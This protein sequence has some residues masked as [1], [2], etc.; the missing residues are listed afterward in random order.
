MTTT[1]PRGTLRERNRQRIR[2]DIYESAMALFTKKGYED[3][4]IDD[5]VEE[6]GV[7]KATF[8]RSFESK[9]GLVDEFNQRMADNI[10]DSIDLA[11]MSPTECIRV[12]TD[13]IFQEWLQSAPQMRN[14][15]LEFVRTGTRISEQLTDPMTRGMVPILVSIIESGQ[16]QGEF[17]PDL[18]PR[19]VAALIVYAW[20]I[21]SVNWFD[22]ADE[23]G[24]NRS[25]HGLVELQLRG[26]AR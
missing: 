10:A 19:L 11:Q 23:D 3:V 4:T 24:F 20:T 13:T 1:K 18:D 9:Y 6:A 21:A 25:I 15:A 17:N 8:F 7:S 12:A 5:I 2:N 26:L 16:E 22:D 14:L